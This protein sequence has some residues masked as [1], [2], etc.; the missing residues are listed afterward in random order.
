LNSVTDSDPANVVK[1]S[2]TAEIDIQNT[3][4][5][6]KDDG[7]KCGSPEAVEFVSDFYGA[8]VV[9]CFKVI[10]K[11]SSSLGSIR[12]VNDA[13]SFS[14]SS[15]GNLAPGRSAI[16]SHDGQITK[17]LKNLAIVTANPIT[18]DGRDI[19]DLNDVRDEDPSS[20]GRKAHDPKIAIN[21]LVYPGDS[22]KQPCGRGLNSLEG[23]AG[24]VVT[25][26]FVVENKGSSYL[27]SVV[28]VSDIPKTT[29]K[30]TG[31]L[32]PGAS[33]TETYVAT[34]IQN[35]TTTGVVTAN[36]VT[37]T[38]EDI[39][40]HANVRAED[41]ASVVELVRKPSIEIRNTVF[42][43][44]DGA[45]GCG[46]PKA[47]E[48]VQGAFGDEVT[49]CFE[50][51]N[52]GNTYLTN[53]KVQDLE[54]SYSDKASITLLK[55][56]QSRM[57]YLVDSVNKTLTNYA[58][59]VADPAKDDGSTLGM[60]AVTDDDPSA[61][62][63]T[64]VKPNI[65]IVN[66]VYKGDDDGKSCATAVEMV[67]DIKGTPVQYC[68]VV[69]NTG[70]TILDEI[71]V[72]NEDLDYEQKIGKL[73]PGESKKLSVPKTIEGTLRN[74]VYASGRPVTDDGVVIPG[75]GEVSDCDP[76]R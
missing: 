60:A 13:L 55:P 76:S 65:E 4:Y 39:P 69:K 3:V 22:G 53:V 28:I 49:Y 35:V 43:G 61:V 29:I 23:Y 62:E 46:T 56:G 41:P 72:V 45:R 2:F 25:Y 44:N 74:K 70:D 14:D 1:E 37:P 15:I 57:L 34:I 32:A 18:V 10:N 59:V 54:L 58:D 19:P 16:V 36:P 30:V 64:A 51:V 71:V 26:C 40:D 66:T 24:D 47:V 68:F 17:D 50:I 6:G 42:L 38:G 31:L 52:T 12:I 75:L 67:I 9:Y 11:G 73:A 5:L 48:K 20:V 8:D 21:T 27:D 7:A 33:T 63:R